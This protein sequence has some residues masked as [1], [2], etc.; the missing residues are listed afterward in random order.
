MENESKKPLVLKIFLVLQWTLWTL[1][2]LLDVALVG[3]LAVVVDKLTAGVADRTF[4]FGCVSVTAA[5]AV[6]CL[7][8]G[9][10]LL[11]ALGRGR[12]WARWSFV[13]SGVLNIL[14]CSVAVCQGAGASGRIRERSDGDVPAR[15]LLPERPLRP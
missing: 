2:T 14:T 12:S 10:F 8:M 6:L 11:V 1:W 3:M 13:A 4:Y 9:A 15:R 5:G 7:A